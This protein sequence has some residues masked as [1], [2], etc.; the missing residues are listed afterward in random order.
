MDVDFSEDATP[1]KF[2]LPLFFFNMG[3][4]GGGTSLVVPQAES[5]VIQG[6][7]ATGRR[8]MLTQDKVALMRV[9][10]M[11]V[12]LNDKETCLV[13]ELDKLRPIN[14]KLKAKVAKLETAFDDYKE[15]FQI[16]VRLSPSYK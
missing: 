8:K 11:V 12:A 1:D 14:G 6:L 16:I 13:G 4:F 3:F 15:K 10:E 7:N 5:F 2:V 9:L